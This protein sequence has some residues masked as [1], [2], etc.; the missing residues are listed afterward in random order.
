MK[1]PL[2]LLA[3]ALCGIASLRASFH[4]W[5]ITEIYSNADGSLQFI[6]MYNFTDGEQFV[7]GHLLK[8]STST[9]EFLSDTPPDTANRFLLIATGPVGGVVP[10][11]LIPPNFFST[12]NDFVN[13]AGVSNVSWTS[14]PNDGVK[15]LARHGIVNDFATPLNFAGDTAT[16]PEPSAAFL[17]I[18]AALLA[19]LH[20]RRIASRP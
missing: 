18:G 15:S 8:S 20:S 6:E 10:D 14:L 16:L 5:E 3:A 9:Y 11:F 13:F 4:E 12:S 7:R 1:L 2:L 19:I 17:L